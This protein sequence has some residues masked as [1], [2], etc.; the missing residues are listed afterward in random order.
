MKF[1]DRRDAG[2]QL[3]AILKKI[4]SPYG[5]AQKIIVFGLP[6][7]GVVP[8]DEIAKALKAPLNILLAHKIGHPFQSEYAI[9]AVSESGCFVGNENEIATVDAK[10]F[11]Q[12]KTTEIE[13]MKRRRKLFK[14]TPLPE[15]LQDTIAII[16]DDGIATGRTIEAAILE[17]QKKNLQ[18]IIVAVPVT[19]ES[20]RKKLLKM[21]DQVVAL[22]AP[23]DKDFLGAVGA[24]YQS[25]D[26]VEDEEVQNI[27]F[28]YMTQEDAL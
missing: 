23:Q 17:I 7:G 8:A 5:T 21:V 19:P 3:G 11:E 24:Y 12:A 18:K 9:A 22:D 4:L 20:I 28:P 15:K 14:A 27:L 16:V 6:R 26:Q 25:F 1:F 13:E 2:K 10:W